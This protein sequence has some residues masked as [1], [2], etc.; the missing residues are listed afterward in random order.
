MNVQNKTVSFIRV[1]LGFTALEPLSST[2]L[3]RPISVP[4]DGVLVVG[5]KGRWFG[6]WLCV[7]ISVVPVQRNNPLLVMIDSW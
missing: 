1:L 3:D 7:C 6:S 5:L 2:V 4:S